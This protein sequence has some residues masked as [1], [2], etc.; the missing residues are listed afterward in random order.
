MEVEDVGSLPVVTED[1]RLVGI[2]TDR[3]IAIRAVAKGRDPR[4]T[5]VAEVASREPLA[6][7]AQADLEEAM[8][9][10]ADRQLRRLPVVDGDA[11]VGMLAQ[12][13]VARVGREKDVGEVVEVISEPT[14]GPRVEVSQ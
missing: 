14:A 9:L 5:P 7:S 10:M 11:L 8:T 13:D 4:T 12:A 3:D 1:G 6:V 2:V